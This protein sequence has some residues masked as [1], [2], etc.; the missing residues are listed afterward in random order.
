[1]SG[2]IAETQLQSSVKMPPDTAEP[3]PEVRERN[4]DQASQMLNS[5]SRAFA[6]LLNA[7]SAPNPRGAVAAVLREHSQEPFHEDLEAK[8]KALI[9]AFEQHRQLMRDA[10]EAV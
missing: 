3:P 8:A 5:E 1:M 4:E 6:Q 2:E 10:R 9:V 7:T